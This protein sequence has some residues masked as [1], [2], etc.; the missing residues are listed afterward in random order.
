MEVLD[1][2]TDECEQVQAVVVEEGDNWMTPILKYLKQGTLPE[3]EFEAVKLKKQAEQ[4]AIHE[5][6][7]YK[8]AFLSPLLR[9]LGLNESNY[10]IREI[11]M[12]ICGT[13]SGPRSI[14]TRL[15]IWDTIG[16]LCTR[17]Q[18]KS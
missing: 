11:H 6:I 9:C 3:T 16:Q 10:V 5:G 1:N 2:P 18:R 12:G 17:I 14:V 7:L 4:Y 8:N 13:H 15:M